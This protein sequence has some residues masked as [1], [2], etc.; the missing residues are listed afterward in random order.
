[1]PGRERLPFEGDPVAVLGDAF[2][3]RDSKHLAHAGDQGEPLG[4]GPGTVSLVMCVSLSTPIL[5]VSSGSN[6]FRGKSVSA[7]LTPLAD[8]YTRLFLAGT[9]SAVCRSVSR[10]SARMSMATI[11]CPLAVTAMGRRPSRKVSGFPVRSAAGFAPNLP[12]IYGLTLPHP[13]SRLRADNPVL[14]PPQRPNDA[15]PS[16]PD[17]G[18]SFVCKGTELLCPDQPR[19]SAAGG[20]GRVSGAGAILMVS[21]VGALQMRQDER[22]SERG[23]LRLMADVYRRLPLLLTRKQDTS[24]SGWTLTARANMCQPRAPSIG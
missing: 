13:G 18:R 19:C 11:I 22:L 3:L 12:N 6:G 5:L 8:N 4:G 1:M 7:S 9:E 10:W 2:D 17:H 20:L 21:V 23:F 14:A 24:D 15:S 16:R